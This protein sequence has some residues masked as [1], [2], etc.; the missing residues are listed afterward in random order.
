MEKFFSQRNKKISNLNLLAD[1]LGH[2]LR[3]NVSL[4]SVNDMDSKVTLVTEDGDVI[5]GSYY[6]NDNI[7]LDDI[8]VD[9]SV[10]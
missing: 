1:S 6:F 3:K 4:F 2:S 7:I 10:Y 5:E 8:V 9:F